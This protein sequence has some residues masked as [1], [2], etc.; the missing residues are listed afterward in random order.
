MARRVGS[1]TAI[2]LIS[3]GVGGWAFIRMI[4]L[5][6]RRF[7][8][9]AWRLTAASRIRAGVIPSKLRPPSCDRCR[10]LAVSSE[11]L[12]KAAAYRAESRPS[13]GQSS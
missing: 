1:A 12:A 11:L 7:A 5:T 9:R 4:P 2:R 13:A 3:I 6:I 8:R 10:K